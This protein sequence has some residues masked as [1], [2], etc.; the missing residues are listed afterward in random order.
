[1]RCGRK[2]DKRAV[3]QATHFVGAVSASDVLADANVVRLG[4][5]SSFGR[6]ATDDQPVAMV[7]SAFAML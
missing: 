4:R 6:V 5:T 7:S 2:F 1:M 3:D